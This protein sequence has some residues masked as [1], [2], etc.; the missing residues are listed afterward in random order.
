MHPSTYLLPHKDLF[1]F[2]IIMDTEQKAACTQGLMTLR[3]TKIKVPDPLTRN[4]D[5]SDV[6]P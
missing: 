5:G 6:A 4:L 2:K 3:V 1:K